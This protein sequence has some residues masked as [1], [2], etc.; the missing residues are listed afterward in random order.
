MA[1]RK[2]NRGCEAQC[3][4]RTNNMLSHSTMLTA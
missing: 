4:E 2:R 1:N 3:A